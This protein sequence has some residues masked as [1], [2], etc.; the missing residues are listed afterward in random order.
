MSKLTEVTIQASSFL[1]EVTTNLRLESWIGATVSLVHIVLSPVLVVA[2][3]W[4]RSYLTHQII[5]L[6]LLE[7]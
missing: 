6:N 5:V 7:E 2:A 4:D 1:L 3:T